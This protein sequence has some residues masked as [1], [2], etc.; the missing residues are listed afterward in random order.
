MFSF[1]NTLT[2][3][4]KKIVA[5][6]TT[7][8]ISLFELLNDTK[9]QD[10]FIQLLKQTKKTYHCT[11][12]ISQTDKAKIT[13]KIETIL[14][15]N[16]LLK[17]ASTLHILTLSTLCLTFVFIGIKMYVQK[18]TKDI[19]NQQAALNHQQQNNQSLH[20]DTTINEN[21]LILDKIIAINQWPLAIE[22]LHL[23]TNNIQIT[24]YVKTINLNTLTEKTNQSHNKLHIEILNEN[25]NIAFCKIHNEKKD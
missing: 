14:K 16:Q 15:R 24:G 11:F 10:E 13:K 21:N 22:K 20:N 19:K 3:F 6:N 9:L 1:K 17:E 12:N 7:Y 18:K 5:N 23:Q 2:F 8:N 25:N 4:D